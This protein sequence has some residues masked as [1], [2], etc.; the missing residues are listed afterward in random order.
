MLTVF[1]GESLLAFPKLANAYVVTECNQLLLTPGPRR[2]AAAL[3]AAAGAIGPVIPPSILMIVIGYVT[4]VSVAQLFL[5]GVVPG[6][7]IGLALMVGA[8]AVGLRARSRMVLL[9]FGFLVPFL[10]FFNF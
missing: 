4:G 9:G 7:L 10:S 3:Q 5:A 8:A 6:V 1:D 2:I